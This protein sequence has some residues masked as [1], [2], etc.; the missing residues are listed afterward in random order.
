MEWGEDMVSIVNYSLLIEL[1]ILIFKY[2]DN[3][4]MFI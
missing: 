3:A 1:K 4:C 2:L